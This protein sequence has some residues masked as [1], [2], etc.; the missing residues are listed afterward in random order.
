MCGSVANTSR[1]RSSSSV[2][3]K[4]PA[5]DHDAVG[6]RAELGAALREV[7]IIDPVAELAAGLGVVL[8]VSVRRDDPVD[9][10]LRADLG[11]VFI[12][13]PIQ[14]VQVERV[15]CLIVA[16]DVAFS[17]IG[18]GCL[19]RAVAVC[20]LNPRR[21]RI[22]KI[23]AEEHIDVDEAQLPP[24]LSRYLFEQFGADDR[25]GGPALAELA[26]APSTSL[27]TR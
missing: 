4:T 7:A 5:R 13:G 21:Q 6:A 11:G 9:E 16:A 18:A 23:V 15:F 1:Q 26:G 19:Q 8:A 10:M 24:H 14:I 17:A 27:Q 2:E 20:S 22:V 3:P 12:L 25:G